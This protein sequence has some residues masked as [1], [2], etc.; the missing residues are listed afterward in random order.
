MPIK[1]SE[2]QFIGKVEGSKFLPENA[3]AFI[4]HVQGYE[5]KQVCVTL[6]RKSERKIRSDNENRYYWGV[7]V[8]ILANEWGFLPSEG[9]RVHSII[10]EQFLVEPVEV[11]GKIL[12]EEVSTSTLTTVEFESLMSTIREWASVEFGVYIPLPNEVPFEY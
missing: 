12:K 1:K 9:L 6:K 2:L 5:G 7:V 8:K 11:R 4:N 10:K 3:T